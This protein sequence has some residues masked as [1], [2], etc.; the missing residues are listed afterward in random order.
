MKE[1]ATSTQKEADFYHPKKKK[2]GRGKIGRET[3]QTFQGKRANR[4]TTAT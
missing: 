1:E 4:V 2:K 3:R